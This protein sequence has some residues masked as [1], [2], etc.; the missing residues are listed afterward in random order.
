M[1]MACEWRWMANT[2]KEK[3]CVQKRSWQVQSPSMA[4]WNGSANSVRKRT[5]GR[6]ADAAGVKPTFRQGFKGSTNRQSQRN[7]VY[8]HRGPRLR[9]VERIK[10]PEN[11]R[12]QLENCVR[13]SNDTKVWKK[14]QGTQCEP[15][16]GE[17]GLEEDWKDGNW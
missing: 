15:A 5:C 2:K 6:G 11:Q 7:Q 8:V 3:L 9:V 12:Q 16:G 14:R 10:G 4:A 13:S 1:Q 17:C